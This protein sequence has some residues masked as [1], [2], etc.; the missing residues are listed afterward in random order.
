MGLL[1]R[2]RAPHES[3]PIVGGECGVVLALAAEGGARIA[4]R[5][6]LLEERALSGAAIRAETLTAAMRSSMGKELSTEGT[7]VLLDVPD[8]RMLGREW[9]A[10]NVRT[11]GSHGR[12]PEVIRPVAAFGEQGPATLL[13]YAAFAVETKR[14]PALLISLSD[15]PF[16]SAISICD[17]I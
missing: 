17:A 13:L 5:A 15:G 16:R 11:F 10:A 4:G 8:S 6:A 14:L 12:V 2:A 9:A 7:V 3:H 1:A